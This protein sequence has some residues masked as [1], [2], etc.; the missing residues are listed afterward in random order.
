MVRFLEITRKKVHFNNVV[1]IE[2]K[3]FLENFSEILKEANSRT[4]FGFYDQPIRDG[5]FRGC[6]PPIENICHTYLTL[7]KLGTLTP[8][9]KKIQK[10]HKSRDT[11]L[12]F[13]WHQHFFTE[14]Q[15]VLV[16]QEIQV[17]RNTDY[18]LMHKF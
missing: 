3:F 10:I 6:W 7:M 1:L 8:C 9:L 11:P 17:Y 2:T 4:L 5:L 16:Y 12:E 18:I 15:Q 13:S 14:N